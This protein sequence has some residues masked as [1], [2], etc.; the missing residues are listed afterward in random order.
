MDSA[1]R[2][3]VQAHPTAAFARQHLDSRWGKLETYVVLGARPGQRPYIRLGFQ[4]PPSPAEL[5]RIVL[6]QDLA[7]LDACFDPVPVAVG[8][9]WVVP[10]GLAHAIGEG[11]L[12]MEVMEPTDLVVR[13]EFEREGIVVPREARFMGRDVDFALSIFDLTPLSVDEVRARC[14]VEP[15]VVRDEAGFREEQ[16]I[17]AAQT[18]CFRTF[19]RLIKEPVT[20]GG[21]GGV[22]V[23]VVAGGLGTVAAHGEEIALKKGSKFLIAAAAEGVRFNPVPGRPLTLLLCRPGR[24]AVREDHRR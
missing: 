13:C 4:R 9:V 15:R 18:E 7:A 20:V 16:L 8:E 6:E 1:M 5:K 24:P 11:L 23:G 19:R 17:G 3:H 14:R 10:G 2:L 12:V 22:E 21:T